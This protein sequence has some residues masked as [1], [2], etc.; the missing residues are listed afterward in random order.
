MANLE[1]GKPKVVYKLMTMSDD[2]LLQLT[3]SMM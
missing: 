3:S 1:F 2:D